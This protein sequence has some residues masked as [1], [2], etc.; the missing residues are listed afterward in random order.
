[1]TT[2]ANF[3]YILPQKNKKW[4]GGKSLS[5]LFLRTT[6]NTIAVGGNVVRCLFCVDGDVQTRSKHMANVCRGSLQA[7]S[8]ELRACPVGAG[9][10]WVM[11]AECFSAWVREPPSTRQGFG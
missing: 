6:Q 4:A 10:G 7:G 9:P 2:M 3:T 5:R 1:M 8:G 11:E